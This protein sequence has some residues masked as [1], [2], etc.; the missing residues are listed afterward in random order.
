MADYGSPLPNSPRLCHRASRNISRNLVVGR[1]VTIIT[2]D[3]QRMY[4]QEL[5]SFELINVDNQE[6]F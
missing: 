6:R 2:G 5:N 4:A 3:S 1:V